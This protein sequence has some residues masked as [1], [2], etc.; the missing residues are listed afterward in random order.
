MP[1]AD[2]DEKPPPTISMLRPV[3]KAAAAELLAE[4]VAEAAYSAEGELL[5][6]TVT[7]CVTVD[8]GATETAA[9]ALFVVL[10]GIKTSVT[11]CVFIPEFKF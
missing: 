4:G 3:T 8:V 11:F 5:L 6:Y 10:S 7:V 1:E 2:A 9:D